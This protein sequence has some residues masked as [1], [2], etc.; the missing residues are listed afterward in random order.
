MLQRLISGDGNPSIEKR[1]AAPPN[2]HRLNDRF[3]GDLLPRTGPYLV[4]DTVQHGLAAQVQP[5]GHKSFK[6]IYSRHGRSRWYHLAN[7]TAIKVAEARKLAGKIMVEVADGK[8]PAANRKASRHAGT[9]E[10]LAKRYA[11]HAEK[12]NKS[13]KRTDKLRSLSVPLC[14]PRWRPVVPSWWLVQRRS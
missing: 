2:K 13:W 9:F 12:K 6:V 14:I 3:V 10:D 5:T 4:W 1:H 7:A 11:K 8:D